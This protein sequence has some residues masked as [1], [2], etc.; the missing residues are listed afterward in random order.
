[1]DAIR[2]PNMGFEIFCPKEIFIGNFSIAL[3][4]IT[5]ALS[6][7][8]GALIAYYEAKRTG[9]KV[10]DYVDYTLF[11]ILGGVV[12]ARIY[13]VAFEWDQY[14]NN[15]LDIFNLREGG[16]AIYGGVIGAVTVAIIFCKLKKM[17]FWKFADTAVLGLLL[18]QI[19]GRWGNFF[20]REAY[21]CFTYSFLGFEKNVSDIGVF[22]LLTMQVPSKYAVGD[23]LT[24]SI[25]NGQYQYVNV[26]PTFFLES[27]LN[28]TL[29]ILLIVFRDKKKFYGET[30]CRYIM[31]YGV[32]RFFIEGFRTDQLRIGDV[33][34]SQ[35]LSIVLFVA[36]LAFVIVKRIKLK[37]KESQLDPIPA[38]KKKDDKEEL[39]EEIEEEIEEY[40][41]EEASIPEN[42]E[43]EDNTSISD[44]SVTEEEAEAFD[45]EAETVEDTM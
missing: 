12:G 43:P 42:L 15:L 10:D 44:V 2:F 17:K 29:L 21:G 32:I 20:N 31:G 27:I 9:Q 14:K 3:Y 4:G 8:C 16:I 18:G 19:I 24:T 38:K 45:K 39:E 40:E 30:F 5:M 6:M 25:V 36:A 22:K 33:A 1:M 26:V 23:G 11:G 13:Y 7:I 35:V 34:V 28:L 41:E 37:G